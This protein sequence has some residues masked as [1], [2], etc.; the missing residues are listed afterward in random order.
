MNICQY[1]TCIVRMLF[2][3]KNH[4]ILGVWLPIMKVGLDEQIQDQ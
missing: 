1:K 3:L 4:K 2:H